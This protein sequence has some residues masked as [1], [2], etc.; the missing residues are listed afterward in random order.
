MPL[1]AVLQQYPSAQFPDMH[2]S[3]EMQTDPFGDLGTHWL[4]ALQYAVGAQSAEL[5]QLV[6][7]SPVPASQR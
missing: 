6:R 1:Q 2:E 4:D 3:G 7:Q 5:P